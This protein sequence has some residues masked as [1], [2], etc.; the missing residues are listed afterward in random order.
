MPTPLRR[1]LSL[2]HL[3]PWVCW[4][5]TRREH[6]RRAALM[7]VPTLAVPDWSHRVPSPVHAI[8]AERGQPEPLPCS[9]TAEEREMIRLFA[10]T[11]QP[12][13]VVTL[14]P[15]FLAWVSGDQELERIANA[16]K[17]PS[18]AVAAE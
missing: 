9:T 15:A 2:A 4:D 17:W 14:A 12:D 3:P 11:S 13:V 1:Q 16:V 7:R 10:T 18:C 5:Y 8:V 6:E